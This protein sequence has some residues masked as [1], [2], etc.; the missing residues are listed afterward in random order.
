MQSLPR[1]KQMLGLFSLP[2]FVMVRLFFSQTN[3][4]VLNFPPHCMFL[5]IYSQDF[6]VICEFVRRGDDKSLKNS[7]IAT[8]KVARNTQEE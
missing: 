8:R 7:K 5:H 2:L 3:S 1:Q 4:F 6:A